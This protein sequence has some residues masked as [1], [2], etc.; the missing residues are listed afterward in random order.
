MT[1]TDTATL[2][3]LPWVTYDNANDPEHPVYTVRIFPDLGALR[4]R[5]E[6]RYGWGLDRAD[7]FWWT[8]VVPGGFSTPEAAKAAASYFDQ[9]FAKA[10]REGGGFDR[11]FT[12]ASLALV[13]H[14]RTVPEY[15]IRY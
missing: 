2:P 14:L 11:I 15:S 5:W 3:A 1:T 9:Q 8:A 4:V 7:V 13:D 6:A 10:R 12:K